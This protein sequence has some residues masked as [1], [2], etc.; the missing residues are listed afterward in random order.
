[1]DNKIYKISFL[2]IL[3]PS[4]EP[5]NV[6]KE[7]SFLFFGKINM[8]FLQTYCNSLLKVLIDRMVCSIK[9]YSSVVNDWNTLWQLITYY[10]DITKMSR[11]HLRLARPPPPFIG[12]VSV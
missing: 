1:M 4:L 7:V 3:Q 9:C 8:I 2:N 11:P 12:V 10:F 5:E 6:K